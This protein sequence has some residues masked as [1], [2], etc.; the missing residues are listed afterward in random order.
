MPAG[1]GSLPAASARSSCSVSRAEEKRI[2][3]ALS[4]ATAWPTLALA[5]ILPASFA[6]VA[7]L[8]LTGRAPLWACTVILSLVSYAHY[9]LVHE[10]I[11]GNVVAGQP[12]LAWVN[13]VVGWVGSLGLGIGWPALQRTHVLHH[14]HTNTERDPDIFVK[15]TLAQLVRKWAV[16][17]CLSLIP[18]GLMKFVAPARYRRL[19]GVFSGADVVQVSAVTVLTLG[20]LAAALATGHGLDWLC[21]WFIPTKIAGLIL[22]IFFQW[23]PHYPFER[24]DRYGNTRISL[25][26]GGTFLTLQ[27]NLHLMH[28]LWPSVPFYNYALLYRA[29]RPVL[30]E[31]GSRIEGF[32]V[33]PWGKAKV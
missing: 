16:N 32:G 1:S 5:V 27:Q 33:G 14:S 12:A 22:N 24:T 18:M 30:I 28:H 10:S 31:E 11:H 23:L 6:A 9:T 19:R 17:V 15:G 20:L 21:L 13:T 7:A 2:A 26:A 25:W 29:L 4:P 8:G 3:K